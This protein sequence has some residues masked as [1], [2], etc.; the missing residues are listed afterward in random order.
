MEGPHL[1]DIL[2]QLVWALDYAHKNLSTHK[3]IRPENIRFREDGTPILMD[4]FISNVL[5]ADYREA[6]MAKG[7]TFGSVHYGSPEQAL[8]K[9]PDSKS[10]IYSL[11]VVFYEMLTG[12]VPYNAEEPVAIENQHIMEPVPQLP[13]HLKIYQPLL[14]RMMAK[15]KEARISAGIE[16]VELIDELIR[17]LPADSIN[18]K[19][20]Q[21]NPYPPP[22]PGGR[23]H[24]YHLNHWNQ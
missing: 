1:L 8:K 16:L 14:D 4:L 3:N 13:N 18:R 19:F 21:V 5:G 6:L 7:I 9:P 11:G 10:D 2:K 15:E 22:C 23:N 12:Q 20:L 17:Q 24:R